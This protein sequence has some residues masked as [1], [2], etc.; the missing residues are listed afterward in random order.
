MRKLALD[1]D[2]KRMLDDRVLKFGKISISY[3]MR[4]LKC[5]DSMAK[6]ICIELERATEELLSDYV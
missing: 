6:E 5:S 4:K 3:L 1:P 2:L